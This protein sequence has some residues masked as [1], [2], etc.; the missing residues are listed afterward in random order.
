MGYIDL[1]CDTLAK[2]FLDGEKSIYHLPEC[3]VD[4][5]RLY[6]AKALAQFFAIFLLP[7]GEQKIADDKYIE[8]LIQILKTTID[9][10]PD[11]I[12]MAKNLADLKQNQE[13]GKVSA[14]LTIEDGRC[15]NG[16]MENLERYYDMGVRLISLTWNFENCFGAPNSVETEVMKRGLTPFGRDA[17]KRMEELGMFVDV[18]HLSDGGFY[19]VADICKGPFVA[20]HSNCREL[21]SV[22]RNL[23][24][25][26]IRVIA[27]KGGV[28][29]LNFFGEFLN[30]NNSEESRICDMVAHI[31]HM[32][33][34]GG[35]DIIAIG[36]DF[37]G[38][39]GKHFEVADPLQMENLFHALEK[40]GYSQ[41]QIDKFAY[42]NVMRVIGDVLR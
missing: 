2:A 33:K 18:S 31:N 22:P 28:A 42:G 26:M 10:N 14:F 15:V 6:N 16:K 20:S 13:A 39:S 41:R 12:G 23:T 7:N 24:N 21:T 8:S 32:V 34:Y 1:H 29:G 36:S 27:Q 17:V 19:E 4:V 38:I 11:K 3:M 40:E 5:E 35:E 30:G 25:D 9:E 37:D